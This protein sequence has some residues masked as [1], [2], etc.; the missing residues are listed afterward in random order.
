M[1]AYF[2]GN[3]DLRTFSKQVQIIEK[4]P[5]KALFYFSMKIILA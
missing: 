1:E 2:Y 4:Y 5:Y 3:F